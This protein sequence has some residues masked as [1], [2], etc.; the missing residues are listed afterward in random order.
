MWLET[1]SVK[2]HGM[3]YEKYMWVMSYNWHL[4]NKK[5]ESK[6]YI[7][8]RKKVILCCMYRACYRKCKSNQ[9][10]HKISGKRKM[11]FKPP[12]IFRQMNCARVVI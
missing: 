5:S 8:K 3:N 1:D 11:C 4:F 7:I 10:V 6:L 9:Q 2:M 12:H